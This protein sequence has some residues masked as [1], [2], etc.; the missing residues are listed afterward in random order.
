MANP[1]SILVD[2]TTLAAAGRLLHG[3]DGTLGSDHAELYYQRFGHASREEDLHAF[4]H[5]LTALVLVDEI[6]WE[7]SSYG[8]QEDP[9]HPTERMDDMDSSRVSTWVQNWFPRLNQKFIRACHL[10]GVG[11]CLKTAHWQAASWV[12]QLSQVDF[13]KVQGARLPLWVQ[14]V[15]HPDRAQLLSAMKAHKVDLPAGRIPLALYVGRGLF[16]QTAAYGNAVTAYAP[17]CRRGTLLMR[18]DL[19]RHIAI[20]RMFQHYSPDDEGADRLRQVDDILRKAAAPWQT[21]SIDYS[22]IAIGAAFLHKRPE[23]AAAYEEALDFRAKYP[24]V[25]RTFAEFVARAQAG[26]AP[27]AHAVLRDLQRSLET[28]TVRR[29]GAGD[30]QL[31]IAMF[32]SI[33]RMIDFAIGRLPSSVSE[34]LRKAL[35]VQLH[36]WTGFQVLL[37][38]YWPERI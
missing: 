22:G 17:H 34:S 15:N 29:F 11:M 21:P 38:Y 18:P 4:Q 33:G 25:R 14:D 26:E 5:F 6:R 31:G 30:A 35:F 1:T 20:T 23:F 24:D 27:N 12:A 16:C 2:A 32:G 3:G 13:D 10:E 8:A 36:P 19:Q 9:V 7:G 37:S 28:R